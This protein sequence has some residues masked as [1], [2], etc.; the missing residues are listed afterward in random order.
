M[1]LRVGDCYIEVLTP[2]DGTLF[3]SRQRIDD[4]RIADH[5]LEKIMEKS[6]LG[7]VGG[8]IAVMVVV[9]SLHV[10]DNPRLLD[11]L[12]AEIAKAPQLAGV[13]LALFERGS[14]RSS[15][16]KNPAAAMPV[17]QATVDMI[18]GAL[19]TAV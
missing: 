17:P 2:E 7:S 6:Q 9:C 5:A 18:T 12:P 14:Y 1:D 4:A 15:F 16:V 8:R 19:G 11:R 10:F 3:V 13:F